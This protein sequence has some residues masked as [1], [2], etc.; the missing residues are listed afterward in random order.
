MLTFGVVL[1][2][3]YCFT[4]SY[5]ISVICALVAFELVFWIKKC[6]KKKNI[7]EKVISAIAVSDFKDKKGMVMYNGNRVEAVC[8]DAT[9]PI[10]TGE[11]VKVAFDNG[12]TLFVVK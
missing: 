2:C 8:I 1:F 12:H 9:K 11:I 6:Y 3:V 5:I 4:Q 7:S 10:I